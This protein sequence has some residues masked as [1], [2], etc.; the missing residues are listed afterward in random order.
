MPFRLVQLLAGRWRY[1]DRLD[2]VPS[3]ILPG[4]AAGEMENAG[5]VTRPKPVTVRVPRP[6]GFEPL[7][8][9]AFPVAGPGSTA[10]N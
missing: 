8:L 5:S 2:P 1:L 9:T 4:A 10:R 3:F 7:T 6:A